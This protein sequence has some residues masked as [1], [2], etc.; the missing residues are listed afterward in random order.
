M[1]GQE[2]KAFWGRFSRYNL[3][4]AQTRSP[5]ACKNEDTRATE[6]ESLEVGLYHLHL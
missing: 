2:E 5:G 3:S 6:S 1:K 4:A